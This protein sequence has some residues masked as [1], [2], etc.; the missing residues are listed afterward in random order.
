MKF[1]CER[2]RLVEALNSAGRA[3]S[4]RGGSLPVLAGLRLHLTGDQLV[5]TGSDLDLTIVVG[6]EVAGS[7][8]GLAVV[9]AKL[10]A[11]VVRSMSAGAVEFE[12]EG[13]DVQLSGGRSQFT[14][15]T[16]PP[17]E[18][19]QLPE[20]GETGVTI[21]A[22]AFLQALRQVV[23]AASSDDA[24][25]ILTGVLM[26]AEGDG[27]RVVA[28]D[29]Y[30]LSVRDLAG[31]NPLGE[32]S[33]ILVPSRALNELGRLAQQA[34]QLELYLGA[35]DA[36]FKVGDTRLTTRLI[37]GEFP[38]YR[39]L[40]PSN[41]PNAL[42][43]DRASLL[44]A[45]RR[46]RLLAQESTPIRLSMT[47]EGLEL[48]AM[49]QDVGQ[50][51]EWLDATYEGTDLTVAFNA[52]YLFDGVDVA[53]GDTVRLES[54]DALKP[55]VLRSPEHPEFLYLLMPVRVS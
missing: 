3:V 11:D 16:M 5:L 27:L 37:E 19:P 55:A 50:A 14:L 54:V 26:A 39:G 23:R 15:R 44:E 22:D 18:Y 25:P 30:R 45:I 1:R 49:T 8:D 12:L 31:T 20:V 34:S 47:S 29:S 17:D 10:M 33:S 48:V 21:D 53:P 36:S 43:V 24:R 46:V 2:D 32:A 9:P 42:V 4:G 52:D 40:I 35:R 41:Q 51:R 13:T 28:T 7:E 38:N 6:I